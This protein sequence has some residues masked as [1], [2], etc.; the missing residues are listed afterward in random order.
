VYPLGPKT[1][2]L[3]IRCCPVT[4]RLRRE[5]RQQSGDEQ[6]DE[7]AETPKSL[8]GLPY[9]IVFAVIT[10]DSLLMYD[11][12][13]ALPFTKIANIHYTRLSDLSWFV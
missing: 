11:T 5:K 13:N 7:Q 9:R 8:F 2:A 12:Q 10:Q 3:A 4:F 6:R 1:T